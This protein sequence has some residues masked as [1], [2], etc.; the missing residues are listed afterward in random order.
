MIEKTITTLFGNLVSIQG[1]YVDQA[2]NKRVDLKVKYQSGSMVIPCSKLLTPIK[3]TTVP[4]KFSS[5]MNTLYYYQWKPTDEKQGD[6][7]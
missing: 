4:D 7:I 6:L 2:V 1:K 5:K 3:K